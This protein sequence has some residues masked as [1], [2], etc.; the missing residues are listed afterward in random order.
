MTGSFANTLVAQMT[1][2]FVIVA[3]AWGARDGTVVTTL[4]SK[5][6]AD[7]EGKEGL[8]ITV[9]YAP[10]ASTPKHVH[11][12]HVFV[13]MLEGSVNMQVEGGERV[14]L[15]PGDTFYELPTDVHLVS[16]NA[17]D[18]EPAKFLVFFVKDQGVPP[19]TM[20]D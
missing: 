3:P 1:L 14:T 6:F 15:K 13:Y 16:E 20:V 17:S 9:E 2:A 11:K 18:T 10:G 8:V 19:V 5:P 12:A 7:I 4:M